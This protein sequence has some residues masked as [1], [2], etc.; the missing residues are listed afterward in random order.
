MSSRLLDCEFSKMQS[1]ETAT[2]VLQGRLLIGL[3]DCKM[4]K[5]LIKRHSIFLDCVGEKIL[6]N[7]TR[8]IPTNLKSVVAIKKRKRKNLPYLNTQHFE[9]QLTVI[10][11][12]FL[13]SINNCTEIEILYGPVLHQCLPFPTIL[14]RWRWEE[15]EYN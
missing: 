7:L 15:E 12:L 10:E 6:S 2:N 9:C 13:S 11:T 5:F 1:N 4:L 8:K 14:Y 3:I